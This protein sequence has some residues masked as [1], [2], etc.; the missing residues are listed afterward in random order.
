VSE[1]AAPITKDGFLEEFNK[2]RAAWVALLDEIPT[3]R[4]TDPGASGDWTVKDVV[5]HVVWHERE[6]LGVLRARAVVGSELWALDT[7]PRNEAIYAE[8]RD[9]PL[10]E[11]QADASQT[12][13]ELAAEV[14][15][16]T[17]E[18]LNEPDRIR[19]MIP[20]YRPWQLLA[21]NTYDHYRDHRSALR[22]W[23]EELASGT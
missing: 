13:A 3:A 22:A 9:R 7:Q 1:L 15:R 4:W 8:S 18:D 23:L 14:E 10:A 11:V 2:E 6:I 20:G 12:G 19:D 17:E 16:L 21:D 5:A